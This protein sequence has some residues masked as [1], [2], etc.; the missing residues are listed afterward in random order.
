MGRLRIFAAAAA[1]ALTCGCGDGGGGSGP[2]GGT[3]APTIA[4]LPVTLSASSTNVTIDEGQ[5]ATFGFAATYSGS[6]TS[7]VVASVQVDSRRYVL[8][9]TPTANGNS[10]N[11]SLKTVP[12]PPG[13]ATASTVTF[14]LCTDASCTTVYPGST[15]TFT[16]NLDVRLKDWATF[17]RDAAHTGY[18]AVNYTSADFASAWTL[19]ATA[20]SEIAARRGS[21]F[22]NFRQT[23]GDLVTRALDPANGNARWTYDLGTN[24]YSSGPSYVNGRVASM[25]M[26]LSSGTLPMPIISADAGT[27]VGVISYASQFSNGGVPTPVGDNLYFQA[28]YY[29]D[30]VY[31]ANAATANPIWTRDTTQPGEGYVQEGASVAADQNYVYFFGGGNLFA[32]ARDTGAIAYKIRNPYFTEFGLSYFG[33]Y[34]GAPIL[35]SNGRIFTFSDNRVATTPLPLL[36]FSL[37]S[38]APLWRTSATYVGHPALRDETLFAIRAN[39]AIV[40]LINT[41]DGTVR[42]SIDLGSANAPLVSNVI[43][44]GSHLFVAS[45]TTTYAVDLQ[46]PNFPVVWSA[47][48]GGALAITPDNLLTVSA[49]DGLFA[50]RLAS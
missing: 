27:A 41:A 29:G 49:R 17:Q 9:G 32:L 24:N 47:P 30:V 39:S 20:P 21:I 42:G 7:P 18:V 8:D 15:Q 19:P 38:A 6:S 10:F 33:S 5:S 13:G 1:L 43:V 16:V 35:G 11:V 34:R 31:A 48:K 46:Q 36:A 4:T 37:S 23:G 12:L 44:T 28:G 3:P 22:V 14:R 50:Y 45:D 2:V 25:A 40:D 26:N